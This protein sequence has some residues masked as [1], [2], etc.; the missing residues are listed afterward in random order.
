MWSSVRPQ[1]R[2]WLREAFDRKELEVIE[3]PDRNALLLKGEADTLARAL[4]MV[5]VLD[6]PLL[7]GRHGLIVEPVFM[8]AGE[9]AQRARIGAAGRGLPGDHWRRRGRRGGPPRARGRQQGRRFRRGREHPRS[10]RAVGAHPRHPAEGVDRGGGVHLRGAQH[11]GRGA[12]RRPSTRC[13][14]RDLSL[15]RLRSR[16]GARKAE[17]P[18]GALRRTRGGAGG[19]R[20]HR[21]RQEPQPDPLPRLRQGVGGAPGGHREARPVR[22]LGADR[23]AGGRSQSLPTRRRP[24]SISSSTAPSAAGASPPARWA[25]WGSA[26]A[27]SPSPSTAPARPGRCSS[28]STRTTGW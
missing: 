10:R 17:R 25:P 19:R 28:S 8:S 14:A 15:P 5:E 12:D 7:R 3:D 21:G 18:L 23:G 1:V 9:L 26:A 27:G 22:S 16:G 4:A 2:N 11:P 20:P 6:Q 13:S 24:A